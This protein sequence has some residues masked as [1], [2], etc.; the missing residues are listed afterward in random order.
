LPYLIGVSKSNIV[1]RMGF[2]S[3]IFVVAVAT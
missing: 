1:N 2:Y 3:N